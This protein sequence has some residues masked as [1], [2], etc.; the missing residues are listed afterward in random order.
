VCGR[1][2]QVGRISLDDRTACRA[3]L[4]LFMADVTESLMTDELLA[5]DVQL[6][7][8]L[9][10]ELEAASRPLVACWLRAQAAP[11]ERV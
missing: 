5:T 10:A 4:D 7:A 1:A 2:C 9:A 11:V 3:L 6:P 8:S